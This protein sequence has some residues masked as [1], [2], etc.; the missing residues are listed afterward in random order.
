MSKN[1]KNN[2]RGV[3]P[4]MEL[5]GLEPSTPNAQPFKNAFKKMVGKNWSAASIEEKES[6]VLSKV[7][8]LWDKWSKAEKKLPI[9]K[10]PFVPEDFNLTEE[11]Y[12]LLPHNWFKGF[13]LT[14]KISWGRDPRRQGNVILTP[15]EWTLDV[16]PDADIMMAF[17]SRRTPPHKTVFGWHGG[18]TRKSKKL[19]S[20][21]YKN[22]R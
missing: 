10:N 15:Y 20:R 22:R 7:N 12:E 3:S 14:L 13:Y 17:K 1:F 21:T 18:V 5:N 6:F 11:E 8:V 9:R 16:S 19:R 4:N 2:L